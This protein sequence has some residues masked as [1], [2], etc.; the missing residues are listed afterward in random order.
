M[1]YGDSII[2]LCRPAGALFFSGGVPTVPA[3]SSWTRSGASRW[4]NVLT[5][6][7]ALSM[8]ASELSGTPGEHGVQ[9]CVTE[10]VSRGTW[11]ALSSF[12]DSLRVA[13]NEREFE[14]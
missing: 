7:T 1:R 9:R 12:P 5:R 13:A 2:E 6:L 3:P 8:E 11:F 14:S 10:T 4:A